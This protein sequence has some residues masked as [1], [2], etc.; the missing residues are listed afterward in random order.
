MTQRALGSTLFTQLEDDRV[1]IRK[2]TDSC[3]AFGR[4]RKTP[5]CL[6]AESLSIF[7]TNFLGENKEK[8]FL[9]RFE[10]ATGWVL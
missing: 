9:I 10:A 1:G 3:E 8:I 5:L 7:S 2:K 6:S 4:K